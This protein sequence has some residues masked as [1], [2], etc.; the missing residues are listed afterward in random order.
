MERHELAG[1]LPPLDS[2]VNVPRLI[3]A[4]YAEKPDPDKEAQRVSFGTSGHRGSSLSGTFNEAHILAI[5]Q[6]IC[7]YRA[8]EG[9]SGPLFL[10]KDTHALSEPAFATA[11]EVFAANGVTVMVDAAGRY[12]PTPA[13]SHA[14]LAYNRGRGSGKADGVV[15]TPSHNPPEDGGF[16]YNPPHGGPADTSETAWIQECAN[17]I[18][19]SGLAGVRRMPFSRAKAYAR[20]YDYVGSYVSELAAVVDVEA[21]AGAGVKI[22][23]DPLGGAGVDYWEPI[24]E[25]YRLNLTVARTEVDPTF[26]FMTLDRDGKIRMDC[27]S[28]WAMA[29]LIEMRDEFDLAFA[30][31]TDYDRHGIV[32]RK[33]GLMAPNDYLCVAIDYL[34]RNRSWR[35][36]AAIGKTVVSTALIDR[37]AARLERKLVEVPVGF[38]FFVSGLLGGSLGFAGEESAGASFLRKDGTVWTTDKDGIILGLLA[39]EILAKTGKDPWER[40]REIASELGEPTFERLEEKATPEEKKIL[41]KLSASQIDEGAIAGEKIRDVLT[42]APGDRRPIG[43][44][45]VVL[46]DGSWFVARP[47][48]TEDIYKVYAETFGGAEKLRRVQEGAFAFLRKVFAREKGRPPAA[49]T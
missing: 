13:V 8:S 3:V 45:K 18:L 24:R 14:I 2:L 9:V 5:A 43:G 47:S 40:Y 38:K 21:I 4:Y 25:R 35:P 6:A 33:G 16:K 48:G 29:R 23:V 22:G 31:D 46:E 44:L 28:P 49:G 36:E 32:T 15:I 20:Q 39:A 10:G 17:R 27:S 7:L 1:R 34:F 37:I 41:A 26:R 19:D 42:E 12:T 30:N 11:L